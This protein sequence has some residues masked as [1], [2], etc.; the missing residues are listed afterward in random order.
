MVMEDVAFEGNRA[1]SGGA[2]WCSQDTAA[3]V[4]TGSFQG[5]AARFGGAI[6]T[7]D[8]CMLSLAST[9]M[10][11]NSA[12]E[13]GGALSLN[14]T[15]PLFASG[16]I[17]A[18]SNTADRSG[19]AGC[20][21]LKRDAL[22][23]DCHELL[24]KYPL[25]IAQGYNAVLKVESNTAKGQGGAFFLSCVK[26][27]YATRKVWFSQNSSSTSASTILRRRF[28]SYNPSRPG[29]FLCRCKNSIACRFGYRPDIFLFSPGEMA[30]FSNRQASGNLLLFP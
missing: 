19:G 21:L 7:Q 15:Q 25:M 28:L 17:R 5:N 1:Q 8:N 27:G 30:G 11:A 29:D 12:S 16:L 6:H 14:S 4:S 23:P 13:C 3:N 2:L 24:G 22:S 18:V 10:A 20:I 26:P 9:T